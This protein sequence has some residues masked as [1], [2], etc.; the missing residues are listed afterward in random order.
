MRFRGAL[1]SVMVL[2]GESR[3]TLGIV[4][5]LGRRGIPVMVGGN[6][7]LA[8]SG[9]SRYATRRFTYPPLKAG[10][11][12]THAAVIDHVRSWQPAALMPVF[13]E[14]WKPIYAFYGEYAR[15]TRIVPCPSP[16]LFHRLLDKACLAE[17]AEQHGVPIPKT[18][19][20]QTIDEAMALSVELPYPVLLK[21]R[22]SSSGIGIR[23]VNAPGEMEGALRA[24]KG[25]PIIQ[26]HIEG[27]DL[28]LTILCVHGQPMA[29]SAYV[30]LRNYPLP[31]G[32]PVA[33]RT[34]GD[35][36]LMAI[37][38]DFLK[39][40]RY[41]GVA[42][43][44]FRRDRRDGQPKLLD[45]NPRIAGTNEVSIRTGIDF[46]LMLYRLALGESVE[47]AFDYEIGREFRWLM[48]GELLHLIQTPQKR[49]TVRELLRW[50]RVSTD[51]A[52]TDLLP[53]LGKVLS[54]LRRLH[55]L[56]DGFGQR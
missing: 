2:D 35:D 1:P 38:V 50:G 42:H 52:L 28:E 51:V 21:P 47:P 53:H 43:L 14:G 55:W 24:A 19:R 30:S 56:R 18:F 36:H 3:A 49:R 27:Q 26:E 8:M 16:E 45:F 32:P 44:D 23:R 48:Y 41:H 17:S 34:I 20:P 12:A 54:T 40:L 33:C 46:A 15:L 4:R 22:R 25:M 10:V 31:Y 11:E 39:R 6:D 9:F 13:E 7:P 29:G 37:G 5:S